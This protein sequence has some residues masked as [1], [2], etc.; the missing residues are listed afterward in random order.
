MEENLA[1]IRQ[2][3]IRNIERAQ[4]DNLRHFNE[5]RLPARIFE[6]GDLVVV[7][8]VDTSPGK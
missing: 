2:N 7:R 1:L 5:H 8:N 6:V 4:A 3:A